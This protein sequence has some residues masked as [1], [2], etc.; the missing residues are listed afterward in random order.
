MSFDL[1]EAFPVMCVEK[2]CFSPLASQRLSNARGLGLSSV[3]LFPLLLRVP[4]TKLDSL[5]C[6]PRKERTRV[7]RRIP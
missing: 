2:A 6:T 1:S 7:C 4:S 3:I 5:R